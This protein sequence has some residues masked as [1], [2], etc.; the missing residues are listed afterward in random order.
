MKELLKLDWN[1]TLYRSERIGKDNK[2]ST[3]L[4][5]SKFDSFKKRFLQELHTEGGKGITNRGEQLYKLIYDTLT[6]LYNF[7]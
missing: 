2:Y 5:G 1:K 6:K 3:G 7:N 4:F